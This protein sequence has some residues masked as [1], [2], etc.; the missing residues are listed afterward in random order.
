MRRVL[1]DVLARR[2][3]SQVPHELQVGGT[4][5][6]P[7]YGAARHH[8]ELVGR[9]TQFLL[10]LFR[11]HAGGLGLEQH[12]ESLTGDLLIAGFTQDPGNTLE[13][14][15]KIRDDVLGHEPMR[16]LQYGPQRPRAHPQL[17]H[18][19]RG[20]DPHGEVPPLQLPGQAGDHRRENVR[21]GRLG[22]RFGL[23]LR[24]S[25]GLRVLVRGLP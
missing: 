7:A 13:A 22:L 16:G 21:S 14:L 5:E 24:S 1:G 9:G 2:E 3:H 20:V 19:V 23:R 25:G 15:F 6:F 11:Y 18:R 17:V 10:G 12:V 4:V 8:A